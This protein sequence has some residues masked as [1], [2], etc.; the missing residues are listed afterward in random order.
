MFFFFKGVWFVLVSNE[1]CFFFFVIKGVFSKAFFFFFVDW[2]VFF[3]QKSFFFKKGLAF[4]NRFE[5]F[6]DRRV[7][8]FSFDNGVCFRFQRFFLGVWFSFMSNIFFF[9]KKKVFF[10]D[11]FFPKAVV[12][13]QKSFFCNGF[14]VFFAMSFCVW[15]FANSF[16]FFFLQEV[17]CFCFKGF[18]KMVLCFFSFKGCV[19]VFFFARDFLFSFGREKVFF[20]FQRFF[21]VSVFISN[22]VFAFQREGCY[23]KVFFF[24][25]GWFLF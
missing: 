4:S 7:L 14:C 8:S 19:C 21:F 23:L 6:F 2:L 25:K 1:F 20:F 24:S 17:W 16:P 15:F 3:F 11:A 10:N 9:F 22:G 18:F 5:F 12:F 13:C